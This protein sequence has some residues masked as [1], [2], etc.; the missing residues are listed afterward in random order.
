MNGSR[1]IAG[2]FRFIFGSRYAES[3]HSK[4]GVSAYSR[5]NTVPWR[6]G[7]GLGL[8]GMPV[9]LGFWEWGCPKCGD[10]HIT[11]SMP[12]LCMIGGLK[13]SNLEYWKWAESIAN[14]PDRTNLN[15]FVQNDHWSL[16]KSGMCRENIN[17]PDSPDVS[18]IIPDKWGYLRFRV[19]FSWQNLGRPGNKK[20]PDCLG[21]FWHMK[22]RL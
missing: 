7:L 16:Q 13:C 22:T 4:F 12:H 2:C 1:L 21:F 6:F 20:I 18:P 15:K 11:V 3:T 5:I 19:F 14:V 9:S 17:V 10:V 8:Q